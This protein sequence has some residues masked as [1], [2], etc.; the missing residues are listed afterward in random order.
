MFMLVLKIEA[1]KPPRFDLK[2]CQRH[3]NGLSVCRSVC[4][5]SIVV[6]RPKNK[7]KLPTQSAEKWICMGKWAFENL[8]I[9]FLKDEKDPGDPTFSL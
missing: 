9:Y 4:T 7:I 3:R 1:S 8:A 6:L 2:S 5:Y